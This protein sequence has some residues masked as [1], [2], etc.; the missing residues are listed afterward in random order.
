MKLEFTGLCVA[1]SEDSGKAL[2]S[3][4]NLPDAQDEDVGC[5]VRLQSWDE[6]R[7]HTVFKHFEGRQVRITVET[8]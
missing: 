2:I 4:F 3:E 7:A 5:F 1:K 6:L 8:L